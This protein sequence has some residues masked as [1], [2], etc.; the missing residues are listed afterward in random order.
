MNAVLAVTFA[1]VSSLASFAARAAPSD[2][3]EFYRE[4]QTVLAK[5]K[6]LD[7]LLP[8][9]TKELGTGLAKMPKEMQA[10]YLKMNARKLTDLKV[11]RQTVDASKAVFEMTA[12][13]E[14]GRPTSGQVTLVKERGAWKVDDDAWATQLP[15]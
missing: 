4:Y 5:A 14:D 15:R 8:Y 13:T 2:P 6:S 9:Y 7:P 3:L 11:T 10:N 1:L 12:K